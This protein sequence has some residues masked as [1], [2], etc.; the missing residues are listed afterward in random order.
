MIRPDLADALARWREVLAAVA[1]VAFGAWV[2]SRGG[3][4][5]GPVGI[6]LG[7]LGLLWAVHA[8][9]RMRFHTDVSAPGVVE[10]VEGQVSYL[11]PQIGGFV[12][13]DDL[14]DLRL[15][16]LRGRRLWRLRQTDGQAILIPV[17]ATG[18]DRLFDAF[19]SLPGMDTGALVAA[20]R[21]DGAGEGRGTALTVDTAPVLVWH[22]AGALPSRP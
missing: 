7:M 17:D 15:V 22:R 2:A 21:R 18:A 10:V 13:L 9:R 1:L 19:V 3:W 20:L 4:L 11:G 12:A 6:G 14:A 5:L 8:H 16:T